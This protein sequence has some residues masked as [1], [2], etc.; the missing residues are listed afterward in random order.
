M[1]SQEAFESVS[2]RTTKVD[3]YFQ[4]Y[5]VLLDS[6][7]DK[8]VTLIEIGVLGGGSLMMWREILGP[9]ARII[10]VDLNPVCLELEE[11]GFEIFIGNQSDKNFWRQLREAIGL[12]DVIIDDGGHLY[13]QQIMT[14]VEGSN[15]I[16]EKGLII[17]EDT[18]TSF[19][20][21]YGPR[22]YSFLNFSKKRADKLTC[23]HE[24]LVGVGESEFWSIQFFDSL[25]AF[26]INRSFS[27]GPSKK[28]ENM[29]NQKFI[30]DSKFAQDPL[31]S[32][33]DKLAYKLAPLLSR[34]SWSRVTYRHARK[35]LRFF[36]SGDFMTSRRLKKF[37]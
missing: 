11:Y 25:V 16:G 2:L 15:L 12:A 22:R 3:S 19:E 20:S 17:V 30:V 8:E 9:K 10:G 24:D 32:R 23:R 13:E 34:F 31:V 33:F 35:I 5:D 7:R 26:H 6:F 28:V 4:A 37:F 21:E 29:A 14:V 27:S 36:S 18:F 1:D